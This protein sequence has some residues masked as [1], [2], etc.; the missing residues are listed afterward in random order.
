[1]NKHKWKRREEEEKET[2]IPESLN[3]ELNSIQLKFSSF[4]FPRKAKKGIKF[5][6]INNG[7]INNTGKTNNLKQGEG[8]GI[9]SF[10]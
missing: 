10:K 4:N 6:K 1:M 7:K 9:V 2:V 8:E 3:K 5:Q